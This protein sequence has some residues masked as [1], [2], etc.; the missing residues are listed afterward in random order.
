[1]TPSERHT[2]AHTGV[3]LRHA[4][5]CYKAPNWPAWLCVNT[6]WVRGSSCCYRHFSQRWR[7]AEEKRKRKGESLCVKGIKNLVSRCAVSRADSQLPVWEAGALPCLSVRARLVFKRDWTM[8]LPVC[9]LLTSWETTVYPIIVDTSVHLDHF[10]SLAS[11]VCF[12]FL[13]QRRQF[14]L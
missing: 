1:M 4:I 2:H 10:V 12:H 11:L 14:V 9:V 3:S 6:N 7:R 13:L 5:I 8:P